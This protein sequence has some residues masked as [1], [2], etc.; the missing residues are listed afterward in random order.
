MNDLKPKFGKNERLR[1][2]QVMITSRRLE[3]K[4]NTLFLTGS[5]PGTLHQANGEEAVAAAI[6]T[7]LNPDDYILPHH[8]PVAVC[9]AKGMPLGPL[10]AEF[11]G[12]DSG[13]SHGKG[14]SLHLTDIAHGI[15]PQQGVLGATVPIAAGVGLTFKLRKTKQ[16]A[17]GFFGDGA[18]S[19]GAVHEGLN[20][21]AIWDLPVIYICINNR[22][23]A[24]TH[25]SQVMKVKSIAER[26]AAYG[27]PGVLVDGTNFD[28]VYE[29]AQKAIQRARAGDGPT[30]I[31][32]RTYR[33]V[34]HSRRD[35]ANYRLPG[36]AEEMKLNDPVDKFRHS[37]L[38]KKVIT[39]E[40][41]DL[42]EA[43]AEKQIEEAVDF[44]QKA[45]LPRPE[46]ALTTANPGGNSYA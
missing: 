32:C 8:R 6:V 14:G 13:C 44:A 12:K 28:E 40:D 5:M 29:A 23:G 21:A 46:A 38:E 33:M 10:M 18:S 37:L 36:E 35:A 2:L 27:I 42:L 25:F 1:Q 17:V 3:E 22:Y 20:L 15:L 34:G 39:E 24:S 43:E 19:E 7:Q 26:A 11:Y 45:P 41:I 31:E 16:V 9:V 30:L 4:F